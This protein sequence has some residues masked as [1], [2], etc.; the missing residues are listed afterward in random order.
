MFLE[1][2]RRPLGNVDAIQRLPRLLERFVGGVDG[3][4]AEFLERISRSV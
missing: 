2:A 3:R 1:A 4:C